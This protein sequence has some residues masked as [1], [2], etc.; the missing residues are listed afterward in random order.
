M[1]QSRLFK[2]FLAREMAQID[3]QNT[4]MS[5][6]YHYAELMKGGEFDLLAYWLSYNGVFDGGQENL[7]ALKMLLRSDVEVQTFKMG[8]K[9]VEPKGIDVAAHTKFL[10]AF[11]KVWL[12]CIHN[13]ERIAPMVDPEV[14]DSMKTIYEMAK[15]KFNLPH[16]KNYSQ[17]LPIVMEELGCLN[18]I[19]NILE[20]SEGSI[21][22]NSDENGISDRMDELERLR[23]VF[24]NAS[25]IMEELKKL[26]YTFDDNKL[27][28]CRLFLYDSFHLFQMFDGTFIV[29]LNNN[30]HEFSSIEDAER[31]LATWLYRLG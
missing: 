27:P 7:Q 20:G 30:E 31:C 28:Y 8:T 6:E 16:L 10:T 3:C 9:K 23:K 21:V 14:Y 4:P 22:V 1:S 26:D 18:F 13:S 29:P 5:F 12:T 24:V 17:E 2:E 11:S 19:T 25:E 15:E